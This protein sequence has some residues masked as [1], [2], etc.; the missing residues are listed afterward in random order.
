[1]LVVTR[2]IVISG[3]ELHF[4]AMRAQGAGGQNVNKVSTAVCLRFDI[5]NSTLPSRLKQRLL[6]SNDHRINQDGVI[7]IKAQEHRSQLRNREAAM[8]RLRDIIRGAAESRKKRIATHP[9]R[10]SKMKRLESKTRHGRI[11]SLRSKSIDYE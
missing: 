2:N 1:M 9:S 3:K 4:S 6:S 7:L 10:S 8:M 11:K 5:R